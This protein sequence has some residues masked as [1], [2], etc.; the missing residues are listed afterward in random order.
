MKL[1][2][3]FEELPDLIQPPG[4]AVRTILDVGTGYGVPACWLVQRYP[5]ASIFG[6]EPEPGRVRVA[7]LAIGANGR[8]VPGAAP[9]LPLS[10]D[11][12]NAAF[13]LDMCHYL[14]DPSF[15]MTLKGLYRR[16][17]SDG[18]LVIRAVMEPR[19]RLP[20]CWW[21]ENFKMSWKRMPSHYRSVERVRKILGQNGFQV[22]ETKDSGNRQELVWIIAT[23]LPRY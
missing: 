11:K 13:M 7:N 6:I 12:A 2:P 10:T 18:R 23:P 4:S 3:M 5:G 20:W 16:M 8:V 17:K 19:R 14:D 22:I 21:W 15:E 1:D 9:D